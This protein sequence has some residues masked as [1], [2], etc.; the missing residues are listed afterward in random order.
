MPLKPFVVTKVER[1]SPEQLLA[2]LKDVVMLKDRSKKPYAEAKLSLKTMDFEEFRPAQ[3]YVLADNLL[4]IQLLEWELARYDIDILALDGYVTIE[5][6]LTDQPI[7][8]L[9][10]V[11][12]TVREKCGALVNV[13]NDGMHRLFSARLEWK[14]PVVIHAENVS[15]LYPYYAYPIPGL[16]PW[17]Q[18]IILE[19]D[20][21]PSNLIK[22]WHRIADNKLLYRD[23]NS[24][25]QN[26]GGPRT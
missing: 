12:E 23:F 17:E 19:G 2:K 18:V 9:P 11:I 8:L 22:K 14:T 10:P 26:V 5:T 3:R 16:T 20:K 6:N 7:D 24:S 13:I 21:I 15:P 25:F 4:K 1:H